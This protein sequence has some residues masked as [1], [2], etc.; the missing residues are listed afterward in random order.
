MPLQRKPGAK[1]SFEAVG[2]GFIV[3]VKF[4]HPKNMP[5]SNKPFLLKLSIIKHL[6]NF[7][8]KNISCFGSLGFT[9]STIFQTVGSGNGVIFTSIILSWLSILIKFSAFTSKTPYLYTIFLTVSS[10]SGETC[11][12]NPYS[13]TKQ[14]FTMSKYPGKQ[15]MPYAFGNPLVGSV[16]VPMLF[17]CQ[18]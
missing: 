2:A 11:A 13:C 5:K 15:L 18:L 9:S 6:R 10:S 16:V 14:Y 1:T 12:V 17:L 8:N 3:S 7:L 4:K